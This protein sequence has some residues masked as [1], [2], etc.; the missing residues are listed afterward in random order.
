MSKNGSL[1][2]SDPC[3]SVSIRVHPCPS[4]SSRVQ[5]CPSV[6]SRVQP[7]PSVSIRVHPCPSVVRI[8]PIPRPPLR[9][10]PHHRP[11]LP[12][13]LR[14]RRGIAP[15]RAIKQINPSHN[16]AP[17]LPLHNPNPPNSPARRSPQDGGLFVAGTGSW[18]TTRNRR[19]RRPQPALP[20]RK[21]PQVQEV[22]RV[23]GGFRGKC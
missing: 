4:V 1:P 13:R 17:H 21:R 8:L 14:D 9:R 2:P 11:G 18:E 3:P 12:R 10:L 19:I 22:L 15:T 16:P 7:C 6:S 5:P 20:Q 23:V